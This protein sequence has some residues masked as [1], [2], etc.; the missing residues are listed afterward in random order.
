MKFDKAIGS[1]SV[2]VRL[3]RV[4]SGTGHHLVSS[5]SLVSTIA[6]LRCTMFG[7]AAIWSSTS[8]FSK[9]F[10][11]DAPEPFAV[12]YCMATV[13]EVGDSVAPTT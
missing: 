3:G 11:Q 6:L 13:F 4:S 5:M 8:G 10:V 12:S 1:P 2:P 9:H 7:T